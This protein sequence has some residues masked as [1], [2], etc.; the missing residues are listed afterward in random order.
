MNHVS[1]M[2]D[3]QVMSFSDRIGARV[4]SVHLL[5]DAFLNI[6]RRRIHIILRRISIVFQSIKISKSK[7]IRLSHCLEQIVNNKLI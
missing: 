5:C 1:D 7:I 2:I 3:V 4:D 6:S